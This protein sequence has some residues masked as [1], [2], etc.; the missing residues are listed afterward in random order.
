ML[1]RGPSR[2]RSI[3]AAFQ[4]LGLHVSASQTIEELDRRGIDVSE[5]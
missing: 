2:G 1:R 5:K 4:R 3:Q